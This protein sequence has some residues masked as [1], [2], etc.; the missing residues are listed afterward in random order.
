MDKIK[1]IIVDDN[2][3]AIEGVSLVLEQD[4]RFEVLATYNNGKE[5]LE[6]RVIGLSDLILMDIEMPVMDG[7]KAASMVSFR[8]PR[9]KLLAITMYQD[10]LYLRDILGAG[11]HGFVNKGKVAEDLIKA[12]NDIMHNKRIYPK[13]LKI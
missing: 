5:L 12:I 4:E 2:P 8:F 13:G 1:V 7:I 6:S 9:I 3:A 10:Q 11:Y